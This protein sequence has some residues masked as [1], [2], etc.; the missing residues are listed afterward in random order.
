MSFS[1][2]GPV[3]ADQENRGY[4]PRSRSYRSIVD[5]G[6][7]GP[8]ADAR[9]AH[10]KHYLR[11]TLQTDGQSDPVDGVLQDGVAPSS[12]AGA[13]RANDYVPTVVPPSN[14]RSTRPTRNNIAYPFKLALPD[15]GG[16]TNASTVPLVSVPPASTVEQLEDGAGGGDG[17][18]G[19]AVERIDDTDTVLVTRAV[20][21]TGSMGTSGKRPVVERFSTAKEEL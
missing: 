14:T 10:M 4:R 15:E 7:A 6:Q 20:S 9:R 1:A 16:E 8:L 11:S 13:A 5:E 17:F 2:A 12:S 3:D 19:D 21:E 18:Q